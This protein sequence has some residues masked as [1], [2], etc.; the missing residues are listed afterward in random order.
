MRHYVFFCLI[1]NGTN[2]LLKCSDNLT[3]ELIEI[4]RKLALCVHDL[5][6]KIITFYLR[7]ENYRYVVPSEDHSIVFRYL[8][9]Q[10]RN[11]NRGSKHLETDAQNEL[12]ENIRL[13]QSCAQR[14]S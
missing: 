11:N 1:D 13:V 4:F 8:E 14:R 3:D 2:T 5:L 9:Q 6:I 7:R 12:L 10:R